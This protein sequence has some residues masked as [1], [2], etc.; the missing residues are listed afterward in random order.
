MTN[1]NVTSF[2]SYSWQYDRVHQLQ[3]TVLSSLPVID[4]SIFVLPIIDGNMIL[5]AIVDNMI[6]FANNR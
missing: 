1:N 6:H 3:M 4:D 2:T 5:F